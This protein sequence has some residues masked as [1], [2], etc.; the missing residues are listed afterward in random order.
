MHLQTKIIVKMTRGM[1]LNCESS[2]ASLLA[3][4]GNL[5]RRFG[6]FREVPFLA[7]SL[8]R[9]TTRPR[10]FRDARQLRREFLFQRENRCEQV[11]DA[12]SAIQGVFR[13]EIE[14]PCV[15]TDEC[16]VQL[17]PRDWQRHV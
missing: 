11:A 9:I 12:L 4:S 1:L 16:C 2:P 17:I 5:G 6:S 8:E 13:F 7:I 15:F 10:P 3:A 14:C